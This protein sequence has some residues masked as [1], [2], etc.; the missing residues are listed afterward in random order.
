MIYIKCELCNLEQ[1]DF[2]SLTEAQLSL[3]KH[4]KE[5]HKGKF[6]G[7]YGKTFNQEKGGEECK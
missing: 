3:E 2:V 1:S 7:L 5:M 4:E 6:V